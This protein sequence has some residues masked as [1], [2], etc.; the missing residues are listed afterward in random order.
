MED[1]GFSPGRVTLVKP[2]SIHTYIRIR[3]AAGFTRWSPLG[4][5]VTTR[6]IYYLLSGPPQ[7]SRHPYVTTTVLTYSAQGQ[8]HSV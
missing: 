8:V 6:K 1:S 4:R 5:P 2:S 7:G 3:N